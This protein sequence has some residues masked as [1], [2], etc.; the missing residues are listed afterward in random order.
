MVA[1]PDTV[2]KSMPTPEDH[3]ETQTKP[4]PRGFEPRQSP[5][6]GVSHAFIAITGAGACPIPMRC[7]IAE[8]S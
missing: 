2:P 3:P 8:L 1:D 4:L 5:Q 6:G 7:P